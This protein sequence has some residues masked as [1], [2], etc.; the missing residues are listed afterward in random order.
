VTTPLG[1]GGGGSA[2]IELQIGG[3]TC[4]SCA[5]RI[6]KRL[7]RM[8]GVSA[9]VNYAT[10]KA[11]VHIDD[12]PAGVADAA[13]LIAEIE[14]TGYT[15]ALPAPP[16]PERDEPETDPELAS[17]RQ[18]LIGAAVLSVP[19]ILLAMI[20]ALQFTY[21]QWA[22]LALASPVVVWAAWPFH[23]ATVINLRHGAVTMDTLVSMGVSAAYLWSLYA[24]FFG[25][26]GMPGMTH[27]FT[28]IAQ[29]GEAGNTIYLEVAAGVTTFLLLGR[30]LEVRAK[31]RASQAVRALLEVGA[32]DAALLRG[33]AEVRVPVA[34]LRAGDEFVVRPGE[35]IATDGVVVSGTSAVDTSTITGESV[36]VEVHDGDAVIGAT[37]NVGGRLVVRATRVGEQTQ[38]AQMARLV[39]QAQAGKAEVQRLAD[40][41]AGV[42]VPIVIVI[43]VGTLVTWLL[44]GGGT[45]MALTAAIAVLIIACPCALG[46]ATPT[47]LLV[48][49]G[50]GAQLGILIKGPQILES[51][52]RVDTVVLDKTGTVT[53][54]RMTLIGVVPAAGEDAT[55]VLRLAGAVESASEHPIAQAIAGSAAA[56]GDPLPEVAS[57]SS[58]PGRGATGVVEGH[59]VAVGSLG[60]MADW[61]VHP[62]A[63]ITASVERAGANGTTAVVVAWDG[64]ARGIL[65]V[66]DS[67]KPS[68]REAVARLRALGLEP[69]LLT[70]DHEAVARRVGDEVG[71]R[72]VIAG[73]L[74]AEKAAQIEALQAGGRVVAMVGDG[75]NDAAALAQ[76]DLGIAMGTGTD[77]AIEASDLTLVRGD[78][79]GAV[80]AIRLS[81]ATLRT[82]RGNL[83]WAFA[84][85]V[86]AIPLAALGLL[87]PMIAGAAMAA[88]S[89]FVVGNSLRLRRFQSIDPAVVGSRT[90]TTERSA[91]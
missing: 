31:R 47:A 20:P 55:Q 7:N 76:A 15:A 62:D 33:G 53:E 44:L 9:S 82:I 79:L 50:R 87:N 74:P 73:V 38:L 52:R 46:L 43:A 8:P 90:H 67:V 80:D 35:R 49:S 64:K 81:R 22:S 51:T 78:L 85:N 5:A 40:R 48:G 60:L 30:Y 39:E 17:L 71:I 13:A 14:R 72:E 77:A 63:E 28:W 16:T 89:V 54:G 11:V 19:V 4:A 21:W 56:A 59:A 45:A 10:E 75:V 6:E 32:K 29:P 57:F 68:S 1:V 41:V 88:S 91:R 65:N 23:R 36:P 18:R 25:G 69:I 86:A 24:L 83:F 27:G 26:A 42:F 70:G 66:A 3:M 2:P 37:V 12:A 61:S 58:V 34:Q 84:Y